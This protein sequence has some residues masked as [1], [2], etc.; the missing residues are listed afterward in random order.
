M[1]NLKS[2]HPLTDFKRNTSKH[3]KELKE[4]R[5]P[6]VLTVNGKAEVVV[7]DAE[8]YQD[9]VNKTEY[10]EN[11]RA[12]QDGIESFKKGEGKNAEQALKQLAEKYGISS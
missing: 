12:I 5:N 10:G 8:S 9:L 4:S 1:I 11:V 3:L 6:L 7:L 2:I